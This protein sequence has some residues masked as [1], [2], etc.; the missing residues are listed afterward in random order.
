MK[1]RQKGEEEGA[2][3]RERER[4]RD[5]E[6]SRGGLTDLCEVLILPWEMLPLEI[7]EWTDAMI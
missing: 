2:R 3:D 5:A 7:S 6:G 1:G 4:G